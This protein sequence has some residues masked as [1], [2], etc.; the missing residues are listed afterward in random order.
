MPSGTILGQENSI[1]RK[2]GT[3]P[4]LQ[5]GIGS[6]GTSE[7]CSHKKLAPGILLQ[8]LAGFIPEFF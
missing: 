7:L 4:P 1:G 2:A 5:T 8:D 3:P 6:C